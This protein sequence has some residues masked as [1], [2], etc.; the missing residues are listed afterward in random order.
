MTS[1]QPKVL[2]LPRSVLPKPRTQFDTEGFFYGFEDLT[3]RRIEVADLA[4]EL[5]KLR[6]SDV[7]RW[8]AGLMA[9]ISKEGGMALRNQMGLASQLLPD[10]TWKLVDAHLT[11]NPDPAGRLFH[12]RQLLFL[13]QMT[14]LCCKES[15]EPCDEDTLKRAIGV[16]CLMASEILKKTEQVHSPEPT[17]SEDPWRWLAVVLIAYLDPVSEPEAHRTGRSVL[18][19]EPH[20]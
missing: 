9:L 2:F 10:E 11:A 17:D 20:R 1:E 19:R 14:V 13:M 3:G 7:F 8:I 16:C 15:T 6:R 5:G 12:V 18:V 4:Q